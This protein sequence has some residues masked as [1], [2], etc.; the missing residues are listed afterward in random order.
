M[1]PLFIT[2][3]TIDTIKIRKIEPLIDMGIDR[4]NNFMLFLFFVTAF[5]T[6]IINKK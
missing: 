3:D 2:V 6:K 1:F 4:K 5:I